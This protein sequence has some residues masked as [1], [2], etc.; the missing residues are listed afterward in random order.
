MTTP[1][2]GPYS[3]IRRDR[4]QR[5]PEFRRL[6]LIRAIKYLNENDLVMGKSTLY[7]YIEDTV[8]FSKLASA[9]KISSVNLEN[10]LNGKVNPSVDD[11][12]AIIQYLKKEE[13]IEVKVTFKQVKSALK[14]KPAQKARV[15]ST[16]KTTRKTISGERAYA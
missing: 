7:D 15:K 5:D 16:R 13:G 3:E 12:F 9:L 1:L 8:G 6:M 14:T 2:T 11:M 4:A 10:M